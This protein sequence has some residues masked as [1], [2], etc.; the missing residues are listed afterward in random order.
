[1]QS[2]ALKLY[3]YISTGLGLVFLL[4]LIYISP[5]VRGEGHTRNSAI[6][7][8]VIF[9]VLLITPDIWALTRLRGINWYVAWAIGLLFFH[10][11]EGGIWHRICWGEK[12]PECGS[13]LRVTDE[14]LPDNPTMS[15]KT[16]T[17]PKC[18]YTDSWSVLTSKWKKKKVSDN[19]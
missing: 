18:G 5:R 16:V 3:F 11:I 13:W 8:G 2:L 19:E 12:C 10:I 1:M 4:W 15:R 14:P 17:C 9:L 7:S 6:I